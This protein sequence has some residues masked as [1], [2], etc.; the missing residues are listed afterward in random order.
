MGE[1]FSRSNT[2]AIGFASR[3]VLIYGFINFRLICQ[4]CSLCKVPLIMCRRWLRAIPSYTSVRLLSNHWLRNLQIEKMLS[5]FSVRRAP[6]LLPSDARWFLVVLTAR[7]RARERKSCVC[8]EMFG[9]LHFPWEGKHLR[10]K[11]RREKRKWSEFC[12]H[13]SV[14]I[15][16]SCL[17]T[18]TGGN[19]VECA[20][21]RTD[22]MSAQ[23]AI[24]NNNECWKAVAVGE[25]LTNGNLRRPNGEAGATTAFQD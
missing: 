5:L 20:A 18:G 14:F 1:S 9:K 12:L 21:V 4:H 7:E 23:E 16:R 17:R 25:W 6:F 11:V 8:G 24:I 2:K 13:V 19:V 10:K 22:H 3:R 15:G